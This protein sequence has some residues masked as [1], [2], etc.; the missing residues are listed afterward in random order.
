MYIYFVEPNIYISLFVDLFLY[1]LQRRVLCGLLLISFNTG[2][3]EVL[4]NNRGE[5]ARN[6][7]SYVLRLLEKGEQLQTSSLDSALMLSERALDHSRSIHF[8]RGT[9]IALAR[10]G[11]LH[12]LKGNYE[13]S[14]TFL[15]KAAD[16][17]QKYGGTA[18]LLNMYH[19]L[20]AAYAEQGTYGLASLYYY[21]ALQYTQDHQIINSEH[22]GSIYASLGVIW[23][24]LS[25]DEQALQYLDSAKQIALRRKD[26]YALTFIDIYN[27]NIFY[28][29][30]KAKA[31]HYFYKAL[32]NAR[33]QDQKILE[34]SSLVYLGTCFIEEGKKKEG[35]YY[36]NQALQLRKDIPDLK[37][38]LLPNLYL[39]HAFYHNKDYRKAK[40]YLQ[41]VIE[42][43][44]SK[45]IRTEALKLQAYIYAATGDYRQAYQY[46]QRYFLLQDSILNF[47]KSKT[48]D[49]LVEYRTAEKDK[50]LAQIQLVVLSQQSRI[51]QKNLWIGAIIVSTILLIAL[52]FFIFKSY[53]RKQQVAILNLQQGQLATLIRGEEKER[54][55]I[56]RE[57]HDGIGS[58]IS[59]AKL[60]LN[61]SNKA[62]PFAKDTYDSGLKLLDEAYNELRLT[63]H[64]LVPEQLLADGFLNAVKAYCERISKP[65]EFDVSFLNFGTN[66]D[67][68]GSA[69]LSLYRII[70]ELVQNAHKHG[71]ATKVTVQI[72]HHDKQ[73]Y[74]TVEDNGTGLPADNKT[75][76]ASETNGIGLQNLKERITLLGGHLDID[77]RAGMGL[78]VYMELNIEN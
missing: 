11:Y 12:R 40:E 4:L 59:A 67:L 26:K 57:L 19:N 74:I 65:G 47:E 33:E 50:E 16:T 17:A 8:P 70:Q 34:L 77:N 37:A 56:A 20:G 73:L 24:Y 15:K 42:V 28:R 52:V 7:S 32:K 51:K 62:I 45:S 6:D 44:T 49:M 1:A 30:D 27:G 21:K 69:M 78:T 46:Q 36:L 72:S 35:F 71:K 54:R 5:Y 39:A 3:Q 53:R 43:A 10:I 23:L 48:V 58:L 68:S 2:A 75:A 25:E 29:S 9:A 41:P 22:T 63:S 60:H 64:R 31:R 14:V 13:L 66:P 61:N 18:F 55:R 76:V 38:L